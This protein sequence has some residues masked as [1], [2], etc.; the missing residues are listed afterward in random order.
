MIGNGPAAAARADLSADGA[1]V[2]VEDLQVHFPSGGT[3]FL[4]LTNGPP[5]RAVDGISFTINPGETLGLV[6]ESGCGKSTTGRAILRLVRP[7][8]GAV[9][10]RGQNLAARSE[11]ELR[12]FRAMAQIIFQDPFSA[13]DPR[14]AIGTTIAEPLRIHR[15]V[16]PSKIG[17]RVREL[18]R[19]V[20]LNADFTNRYP[21]EF[22]GGQ[23]QRIGIARALAV[24]PEFIVCDE[25]I[26]SLDVSIQA[27]IINLL[28]DLQETK[29]IAYLFIS[30]DL[31][32]VRLIS[33]RV[34]VM[35]LGKIVEL[36]AS[37]ELYSNPL[38]PY[39][40]ALMSA[41]PT[42]NPDYEDS[43]RYVPLGG[44]VPSPMTPPSGCRFRTRCPLAMKV[45]A[46]VEPEFR[47]V[48]PDHL[49]ACHA[50]N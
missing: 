8:N 39:T 18:L 20:G 7:T 29:K 34:A 22:S 4:G 43:R 35:Y 31:R 50:V 41:V 32:V 46:E 3:G 26:S 15:I 38:H 19:T 40:Q 24:E 2:R 33:T 27:Q 23:Q 6:G 44:E 16:L 5:I 30:H 42:T 21:H 17:D 25:P 11:S 1:L 10:Y 36:A 48:R 9:Y 37:N 47:Q 12:P 13:L 14:S 28:I 49:A 45:C